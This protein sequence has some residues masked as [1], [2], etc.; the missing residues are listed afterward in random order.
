MNTALP[1]SIPSG[2]WAYGHCQGIAIDS[3]RETMYF[4]FTTALIKTDLQGRLIGSVT[5]LL[6]HLGCID[7]NDEDGKLYGSLEYKSDAIGQGI[8]KRAG[9]DGQLNTAFYIA[10]FDVDQITRPEMDACRDGVMNTVYLHEVVKDYQ[11]EVQH[12]GRTVQHRYGCSGIDGMTFGCIPGSDVRRLFVAYGI[13]SD[14]ERTDNDH[15]V[16]HC[17]DIS[18]WTQYAKPLAQNAMHQSGPEHPEHRFFV[19][20]GNTNWGVQNLEYDEAT[21]HLL[22]AVY[23]GQKE[24]FPNYD[25]YV[26]DGTQAPVR[27]TL[28]GVEPETEAELLTLLDNGAGEQTPGWRFPYGSTGLCSLGDGRFYVS[29]DGKKDDLFH[30]TAVMYRWDGIHPLTIF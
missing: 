24:T 21:G 6:G 30:T 28:P 23:H 7:F 17:Y 29:Q 16:L 1:R 18:D 12:A 5:G 20:T 10:I 13:Y 3:K 15:Q 9:F 25:L 26:V 11:A 2:L 22:M 4:S 19:H 8:L 27:R 14:C